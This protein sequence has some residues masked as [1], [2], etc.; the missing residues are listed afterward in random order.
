MAIQVIY[1]TTATSVFL[2]LQSGLAR[3]Y[4]EVNITVS[5]DDHTYSGSLGAAYGANDIINMS[6]IDREKPV[7]VS[8]LSKVFK[9]DLTLTLNNSLTTY[10]P[11]STAG[12]FT[13]TSGTARDFLNSTINVWAGF[14]NTSGT[15]Y[16]IKKGSFTL[17]KVRNDSAKQISYFSCEDVL[18]VPLNRYIGLDD[19]SGTAVPFEIPNKTATGQI[20]KEI[21]SGI[22]LTAGQWD[23]AAGNDYSGYIAN[24]EKASSALGKLAQRSDGYIFTNGAGQIVFAP[25]VATGGVGSKISLTATDHDKITEMRYTIDVNN[26]IKKCVINYQSGLS[27]SRGAED[28][29]V[30]KGSEKSL[31]ND[32]VNQPALAGAIASRIVGEFGINRYFLDL[33]S[34]WL[35]SL[36]IGDSIEVWDSNSSQ[37][38]IAYNIY[39]IREDIVDAKTKLYCISDVIIGKKFAYC[40]SSGGAS[41]TIAGTGTIFTNHW[42]TGFGFCAYNENT[43][44]NPA[45][46]LEGNNNNIIN[47]GL[48]V[49]GAGTTGIELPFVCR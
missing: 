19:V 3:P 16:T 21:L 41:S 44:V 39:R 25:N 46:D 37:T 12:I 47:T 11:L 43:A 33:D 8:E 26:L 36:E 40:S 48:A 13:N 24:N 27:V 34:V 10:S 18:R 9:G 30:G 15:A 6:T 23:L 32:A 45:F 28:V 42:H 22:G 38:A 5:G 29:T 20:M 4:W 2:G 17:R 35:P 7:R 49:S 31:S 1:S 14:E